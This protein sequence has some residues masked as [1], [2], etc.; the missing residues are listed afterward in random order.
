MQKYYTIYQ[1]TDLLN[2][3]IYIGKHETYDLNDN[4]MGS[5]KLLTRSQKKHGLENFKKELLF[6]FSSEE[7]MNSKEAELV[8]EDFCLREDTYNI[9]PGGKGGWGYINKNGKRNGLEV[10]MF[11]LEY[12]KIF[13]DGLNKGRVT[14]KIL[15]KQNGLWAEERR[16][17]VSES[18]KNYYN[19]G[20]VN[21]FSGKI[22]TEETKKKMGI[23]NSLSQSGSKN[24]Q[25][26][27]IWITNGTENKKIK[28]TDIIPENWYSGR[29]LNNK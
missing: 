8:T 25:F 23:A 5:G 16:K 9:C 28:K 6:I 1:I 17:K 27:S 19:N 29:K 24:S 13:F 14:Q 18:N 12:R 26:G 21:G 15:W 2:N 20:G 11:V 7:E 22:H 10:T 4:Y 3:K